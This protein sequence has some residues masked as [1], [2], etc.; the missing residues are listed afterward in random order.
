[1]N[2]V[3]EMFHHIVITITNA[4]HYF[5]PTYSKFGKLFIENK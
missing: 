4:L 5:E 1:V 3:Q 2:I